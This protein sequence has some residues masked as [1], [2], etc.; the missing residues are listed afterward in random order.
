LRNR[1]RRLRR[2]GAE[3]PITGGAFSSPPG[4]GF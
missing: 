1:L 2:T 3:I 4:V